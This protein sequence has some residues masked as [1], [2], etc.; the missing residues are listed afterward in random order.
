MLFGALLYGTSSRSIDPN[1]F[2]PQLAGNLALM[3]QALVLLF[4]GADIIVLYLWRARKIP[5][6]RLPRFRWPT[7]TPSTAPL[8]QG[9][10]APSTRA[11]RVPLGERLRARVMESVPRG[12]AGVGWAGIALALIAAFVTLPP[13]TVRSMI[14]PIAIGLLAAGASSWAAAHGL[15][16]L[17]YGGLV[18]AVLC[19]VGG[20][21][22]TQSSTANLDEV[23]LWSALGAST[24]RF[25]TPLVF[26][27]LG[28]MFSE[29]SGVVNIGLEGMMLAGAFFA[30]LGAEK[31]GSW[32]IGIACA[33]AA[34]AVLALIHAFVSIHLRADQIVSGVA[35]NFLALGV[36]GFFFIDIYGRSGAPSGVSEIPDISLPFIEPVPFIGDVFGN[37]NLLIWLSFVMA[38]AVWYVLFRTPFG[39]RLRSVG[40]HPTAADSV[41]LSVF[42]I[43]YTAV[44]VSGMI[45]SLG[46]AFLSIGFVNSFTENITAGRGFI[47][48]AAVIIGSW[49]PK[50]AFVACL[51]FGFSSA[52]AQRLPVYSESLAVLFQALPYVL[53]LIVVAG[54]IGVSRMPASL[55]IPYV[56]K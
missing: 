30:F 17:G 45:A 2:E 42:K 54:L 32:I 8:V 37:L 39:L 13:L 44:L 46:G 6:F 31:S 9:E 38:F 36:T 21:A 12:P 41:G 27:A 48:L 43:R 26:G 7:P 5:R 14:V 29:R 52:L 51:L 16:K 40:E 11:S 55:G 23:F 4:I 50:G 25:A 19:V 10:A 3:I 22:A 18:L 1:V 24:L 47:A 15:R 34:G 28:G 56:K 33:L 35:V 49:R 20:V 53:V